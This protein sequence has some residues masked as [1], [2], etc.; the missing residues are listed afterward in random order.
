LLQQSF[1][2]PTRGNDRIIA[3]DG[4]RYD[5]NVDKR[6]RT[7]V[8]WNEPITVVRPCTWF[9]KAHDGENKLIPYEE[10]IAAKLEVW[11]FDI[12]NLLQCSSQ[13]PVKMDILSEICSDVSY[14]FLLTLQQAYLD[15][16]DGQQWPKTVNL[17]KGETVIMHNSNVMVHF[18]AT[19]SDEDEWTGE[20][21]RSR[22]KVVRRGIDDFEADIDDG[23]R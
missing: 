5:V 19:T 7:S 22:P 11:P 10:S 13:Q 12:L 16:H 18:S 21:I 1:S 14:W 20:D 6:T 4:G 2:N 8:Y 15:A 23:R 9:C 17:E 3:T